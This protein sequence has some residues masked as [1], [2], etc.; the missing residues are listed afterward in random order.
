MNEQK[1]KIQAQ[2]LGILLTDKMLEQF[3]YYYKKLISYNEKVNLTSITERQ[4]VFLKHFLDSIVVAN[5]LKQNATVCDIGSGAGFPSLPLK[6]VRPDLSITMV[7][8]LNKRVIFLKELIVELGLTNIEAVHSRAEDYIKEHREAYDYLVARAVA[9]LN[10]LSE[11][12]IP[13]VK[14]GGSFLA[15]KSLNII[16]ELEEAQNAIK[17]L[18]GVVKSVKEIKLPQTDIIRD[19]VIIEKQHATPKAYPRDKNNPKIKPL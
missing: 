12:C 1:F 16:E 7:D 17:I 6:I 13:F 15:Y 5:L 2:E 4:D 10:T 8:S 11:Y 14:I 19:I 18:G 3:E 9:G